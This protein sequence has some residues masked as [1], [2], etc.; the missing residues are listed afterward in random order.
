MS[1]NF[2]SKKF[3]RDNDRNNF[4]SNQGKKDKKGQTSIKNRIEENLL[5]SKF[6]ILNE[7]LYTISSEEAFDYFKN[8]PEDFEIYHQGFVIQASKW[9]V[10]PNE[11]L[12]KELKK[13]KYKNKTIADLGCGEAILA[14][15][16]SEIVNEKRKIF[17]FDLVKLNEFVTEC[18]IKN[19]PLDDDSVDVATFCLSLMGVNFLDFIIE[20]RRILKNK[21]GVLMVAEIISRIT[22][23]PKFVSLF[24]K[25]GFRLLK[26]MDIKNYL[27]LL[28]FRLNDKNNYEVDINTKNDSGLDLLKP[29]I[30]K[31]DNNIE[32]N[33][34]FKFN[35]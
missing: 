20:A 1:S 17:S 10:N 25:I 15:K 32:K 18:D 24:T 35:L 14:K 33:L 11:I 9:P 19:V 30:C 12:F 23:I 34:N 22:S 13:E 21:K 2:L 28:V 5:G 29:C 3:N 4:K 16:L 31:K 27:V 7:K 26:N 8:N 6:R